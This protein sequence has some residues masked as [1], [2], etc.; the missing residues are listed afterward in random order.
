MLRKSMHFAAVG[1][2]CLL[3]ACSGEEMVQ[4]PYEGTPYAYE[5]TAGFG[6]AYVRASLAPSRGLNTE[7][8]LGVRNLREIDETAPAAEAEIIEPVEAIA[9]EPVAED[10]GM[11][12]TE[13][14]S[15]ADDMFQETQR[16]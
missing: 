9:P 16:K 11:H 1:A 10:A 5:R 2:I 14:M 8:D 12:E 7:E 15:D 6:V 4:V 13:H 3:T